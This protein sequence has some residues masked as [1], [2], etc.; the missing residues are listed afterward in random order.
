MQPL[1]SVEDYVLIGLFF[2]TSS[3]KGSF[4]YKFNIFKFD[5]R[6]TL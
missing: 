1:Y 5:L 6:V 4:T 2:K 3:F